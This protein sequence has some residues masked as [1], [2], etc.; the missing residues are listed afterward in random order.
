MT[1]QK[2]KTTPW[3]TASTVSFHFQSRHVD[4]YPRV[5]YEGSS[6][7]L[8]ALFRYYLE[9]NSYSDRY[10]FHGLQRSDRDVRE[11]LEFDYPVVLP[12]TDAPYNAALLLLHGLNEKRWD[13]YLPWARRL[14]DNLHR[15]VLLFPLAF[16]MNR[17][18]TAWSDS[19]KMI[20][21]AR[22]RKRLF[23]ELQDS[24]FLNVA[25]SHRI[26]F[27]PH[28]FLTSG[29]H[30]IFDTVDL[31]ST[32]RSGDHPLFEEN[33]S[34]DLFGYSIGATI[35]EYLM[36]ADPRGLFSDSRAYLY[37]GGAVIDRSSPVSKTI[38]DAEAYRELF[39]FLTKV[40]RG[41]ADLGDGLQRVLRE[42]LKDLEWLK[43]LLF[44]D[45]MRGIREHRLGEIA[46][47]L[48]AA[49]MS[50]DRVFPPEAVRSSLQGPA[51]IEVLEFDLPFEYRHDN[52]LPVKSEN[53][54]AVE[55]LLREIS[56]DAANFYLHP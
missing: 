11:N 22:E 47:R 53:P 39:S 52:P 38:I 29:L 23:P 37:C 31:V 17:A 21:V 10:L 9:E 5:D 12:N 16:H 42:H 13:K 45:R 35:A 27:A 28:R 48:R 1:K 49:V 14:A 24:S 4:L 54:E 15:P 33:A 56:R 41:I 19:R 46:A 30:S 43:S 44:I 32:I 8:K 36:M 26:Q 2:T 18:P 55:H 50:K 6:E 20:P 34:V 51:P 7:L 25:L 40:F 3:S